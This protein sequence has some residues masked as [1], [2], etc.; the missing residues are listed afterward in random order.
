MLQIDNLCFPRGI[1]YT[2]RELKS[3]LSG[4][5]A[6]TLVVEKPDGPTP[7]AF[8]LAHSLPNAVGHLVTIDVL[9]EFRKQGIGGRLLAAVEDALRKEGAHTLFLE[10]AINNLPAIRFYQKHGYRITDRLPAY[11]QKRLDAY[12]MVSSL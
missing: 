4:P 10:T 6:I 1:A 8:V 11:Y 3:F 2:R 5:Q 12:R 7:I 9:A